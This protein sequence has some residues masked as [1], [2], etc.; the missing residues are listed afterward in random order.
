MSQEFVPRREI[1]T[2]SEGPTNRVSERHDCP[3]C[4]FAAGEQSIV[5]VHLQTNHRKS[6][7]AKS[8]LDPSDQ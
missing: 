5:Y 6:T 4:E 8:L 3:L 2:A 1:S 7:L